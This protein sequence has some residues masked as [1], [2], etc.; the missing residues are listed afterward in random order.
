[1]VMLLLLFIAAF[2]TDLGAWYRQGEEQQRAADVGSLNGIAAFDRSIEEFFE[3]N[4][5]ETWQDLPSDQLRRDAEELAVL[6]AADTVQA[7]LET[8]GLTFSGPPIQVSIAANPL[9]N[10][11][12]SFVVLEAD[13]GT[14]VTIGRV[15][16]QT[17]T[18]LAGDPIFTRA[19]EVT[20]ERDG[21]QFFSNILR[22]APT[23]TRAAEAVQ[24]NCGASCENNIELT[25]PFFG[26]DAPGNG[27]GYT[28]LLLDRDFDGAT[29]EIWAVNHHASGTPV[30]NPKTFGSIIC[31]DAETKG[32]CDNNPDQYDLLYATHT[33]I[34]EYIHTTPGPQF[35]H[36]YF[37]AVDQHL[38]GAEAIVDGP[39]F[40]AI[41]NDTSNNEAGIACF[42]T[43]NR[44]P[45]N[46]PFRSFWEFDRDVSFP[47]WINV[48]GVFNVDDR[49]YVFAQHGEV[50]CV[51]LDMTDC[52]TAGAQSLGVNG[53]HFPGV[54]DNPQNSNGRLIDVPNNERV[55]WTQYDGK[56]INFVCV[57]VSAGN[58]S[59]NTCGSHRWNTGANAGRAITFERYNDS[60]QLIGVCGF[61][62]TNGNNRCVD[63]NGNNDGS[64]NGLNSSAFGIDLGNGFV[65]Q[66]FT[67][68]GKRTFFGL[69]RDQ[70]VTCWNWELGAN[71]H[72]DNC[73]EGPDGNGGVL[74]ADQN[75]LENELELD[76]DAGRQNREGI[77]TYAFAQVNDNCLIAL[78]DE[79]IF[80]SFDPRT[81][82]PCTSTA[83]TTP[84]SPCLCADESEGVRWGAVEIPQK[85][86]DQ[87]TVIEASISLT[88]DG[89]ALPQFDGV[90]LFD[91]PNMI[92]PIVL[93]LSPLD[94]ITAAETN[95]EGRPVF[96][97]TVRV[98]TRI[99][100]GQPAFTDTVDFDLQIL[101]APTLTN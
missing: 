71:E 39:N 47:G 9:D 52:P 92:D 36:I 13:D 45:C 48:N 72:G 33:T 8:S 38:T 99:V 51:N 56:S 85:L 101:V 1:M 66:A 43:I 86:I 25:P 64:I 100:N 84:I 15:W 19:I 62:S 57:N 35:G 87:V 2:A 81:F 89:P 26:F 22:G 67:W 80:Y 65:G 82:G 70:R 28:P 14:R 12:E 98:D 60:Q 46:T 17:G 30:S 42:D 95:A 11:Q 24:T 96:Y 31:F 20:I 4:G 5:V 41:D 40:R 3:A 44:Q 6:E 88:A 37:A 69:G 76:P 55:I 90:V 29:D 32:P 77:Q 68:E 61:Q 21:E 73:T 75:F 63:L 83:V 27:D 59:A 54:N 79:A 94:N 53:N 78:G 93:D 16:R 74:I 10:T 18:D 91:E 34:V 7:L 97:L 58:G 23:I 49:L 50:A